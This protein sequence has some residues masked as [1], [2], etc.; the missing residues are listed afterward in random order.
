MLIPLPVYQKFCYAT[1]SHPSPTSPAFPSV[2]PLETYFLFFVGSAFV[3]YSSH[4]LLR[5][6]LGFSGILLMLEGPP[7]SS[8]QM[9]GC[10]ERAHPILIGQHYV[11]YFPISG[12]CFSS[13]LFSHQEEEVSGALLLQVSGNQLCHAHFQWCFHFCLSSGGCGHLCSCR[14]YSGGKRSLTY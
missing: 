14:F 3:F 11:C 4:S 10:R 6:I 13:S 8:S 12:S 2:H 9:W 1:T 7:A 5:C